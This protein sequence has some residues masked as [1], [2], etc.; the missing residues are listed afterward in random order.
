MNNQVGSTGDGG[1]AVGHLMECLWWTNVT[2]RESP[3]LLGSLGDWI[4]HPH[5][6]LGVKVSADGLYVATTKNY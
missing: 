6:S 5:P 3:E 1:Y 4:I 2:G